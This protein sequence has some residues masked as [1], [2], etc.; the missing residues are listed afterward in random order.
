MVRQRGVIVPVDATAPSPDGVEDREPGGGP[1]FVV[2]SMRSGSTML[3]LILD[4]H[5]NVAIGPETGFMG[6]VL[7]T[8]RIP[9]WKFGD[10][11]YTRLGW[12]EPEID[13]LLRGFY[14]ELFARHAAQ[15]G[16]QRWGDKTP[17]HTAH[18]ATMAQVF[19][20]AVFVGIVRHPGAVA[21]SLRDSFNYGF[22]EALSY[23][24]ATNLDMLRSAGA[25][26]SRFVLCR[27]EDLVG[28]SEPVLRRLVAWLG[29]PWSPD[30]L[31]HHRVQRDKGAP[32]VAEGSTITRDRI[33]PSRAMTW[34]D[35]TTSADRE[36]L[37]A[38]AALSEFVGYQPVGTAGALAPSSSASS[39]L[40]DGTEVARR[41]AQ[42]AG[43]IDFD[44]RPPTLSIDANPEE[45]AVRLAQVE[46]ALA[47]TRSRRSVRASEAFRKVQRGRS[48]RDVREAWTV[49]R[50]LRH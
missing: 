9:N 44:H 27:Y 23:W 17:F 29:E 39:L 43:R 5:P 15:Q 49:M 1:I 12:T 47:R 22:E 13:A 16:K 48:L 46:Q 20:S 2:G 25:L 41:Q 8:K 6:A 14:G 18:M 42:W 37:Q 4:S 31:E 24:A 7:A 30:V 50:G 40:W 19:P 32:R 33:D 35:S 34:L 38:H 3:R 28:Q 36:A 26:G 11:W 21:A 45:L 10:Q